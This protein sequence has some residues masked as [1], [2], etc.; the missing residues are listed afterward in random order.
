MQNHGSQNIHVTRITVNG[1]NRTKHD[2]VENSLQTCLVSHTLHE[3][4]DN[5]TKSC[6]VLERL[7]IFK[8]INVEIV[9]SKSS[10]DAVELVLNVEEKRYRIKAGTE[11]QQGEIAWVFNYFIF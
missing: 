4:L 3:L 2:I 9:P 7:Q 6:S 10:T 1:L 8:S 5:L 11:F